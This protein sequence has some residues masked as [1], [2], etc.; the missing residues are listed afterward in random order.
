[1]GLVLSGRSVASSG[2]AFE[3]CIPKGCEN[4]SRG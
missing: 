2:M 4:H 3:A 1:L